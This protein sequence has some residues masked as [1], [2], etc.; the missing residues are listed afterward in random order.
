MRGFD[1]VLSYNWGAFDAVMARRLLGG[2]PLVHHEDGFN[3]DEA[4][5]L[6]TKRNLYRRLGLSGAHRLVV[7]SERL[8]RIALEPGGR[9]PA[10][11]DAHRRTACRWRASPG[12][13]SPAR[14]PASR[15]ARASS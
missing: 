12:R 11:V 13:P 6:K 14:S 15:R 8:E 2:P 4:E 7:P 5:K 9:R 1:L 3:E 10:R